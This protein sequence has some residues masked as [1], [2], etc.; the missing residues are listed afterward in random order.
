MMPDFLM[1]FELPILTLILVLVCIYYWYRRPKNSPP[2]PRGIPVLGV[3]PFMGLYPERTL[4]KWSKKYG[5]V[6]SVRMG[7]HDWVILGD[8]ATI[9]QALV[10]QS[11]VFSGRPHVPTLHHITQG[12]GLAFVDYGPV[13]K[14]QRKFG[15]V[16]LR[17][18]GV[19][20]KTMEDKITEEVHYLNDAIRSRGGQPFEILDVLS[21][22]VSNNICNIILGR[23]F[24]Y[25]DESFR[26]I[27]HRLSRGFHDP[28]KNALTNASVFAP[29]L[30]NIPPFA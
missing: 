15:A 12:R 11:N 19:G 21:N 6:M 24:D 25:N 20:K 4:N 30:D 28:K 29:V 22:A 14:S 9:Q 8:H 2:G 27:M 17:G 10:K 23:R 1:Y 3:L 13:W 5:P 16:T 26:E 7:R 18:F